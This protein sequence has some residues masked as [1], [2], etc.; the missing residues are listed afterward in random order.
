MKDIATL[1]RTKEIL[2]KHGFSFK[3]S[4]GQ[5]FLI[6]LNVLGNIVGAAGLTPESG[7]LEIGP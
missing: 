6:D 3:K 7:V 2:A 1:H 5:N 4:L